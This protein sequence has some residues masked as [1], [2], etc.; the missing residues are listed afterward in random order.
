MNIARSPFHVCLF[1]Y[2]F[3]V[4]FVHH[5]GSNTVHVEF[6]V[7]LALYTIICSRETVSVYWDSFVLGCAGYP[8]PV[9]WI[10][11]HFLKSISGENSTRYRISHPDSDWSILAVSSPIESAAGSH[12]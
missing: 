10:S 8:L 1:L 4:K 7:S 2:F 11:G 12:Y 3:C 5:P 9:G 6:E